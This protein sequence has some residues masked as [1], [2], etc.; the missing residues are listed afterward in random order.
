MNGTFTFVSKL[1]DEGVEFEVGDAW[2]NIS[3]GGKAYLF[4]RAKSTGGYATFSYGKKD[5][6]PSWALYV[7][8]AVAV[9]VTLGCLAICF[10]YIRRLY[11]RKK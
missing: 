4:L 5:L 3:Y 8:I 11:R 10:C 6:L 9:V 2:Y 1:L 7:I